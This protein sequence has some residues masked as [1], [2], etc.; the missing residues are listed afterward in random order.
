MRRYF[1]WIDV[2]M[3][4]VMGVLG[5]SIL[6]LIGALVWRVIYPPPK[7][8]LVS[9]EWSCTRSHVET[10]MMPCPQSNGQVMLLPQTH[11]VCDEYQRVR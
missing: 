4:L 9:R 6:A 5:L 7:F 8:A 1:D 2:V 3:W 10:Q 11:T